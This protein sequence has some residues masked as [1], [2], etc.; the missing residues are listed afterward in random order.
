MQHIRYAHLPC[1]CLLQ[2]IAQERWTD[3]GAIASRRA[4]EIYGLDIL[5]EGVQV[6]PATPHP[7]RKPGQSSQ[8][9]V[10]LLILVCG[11]SGPKG[12]LYA[13]LIAPA[14]TSLSTPLILTHRSELRQD[15]ETFEDRV[16]SV[17]LYW[18]ARLC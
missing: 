14:M 4:G 2:L 9:V 16:K 6:S 13:C 17:H 3:A 5:A 15:C 12:A 11:Q 10:L 18:S 7:A 1:V 8:M